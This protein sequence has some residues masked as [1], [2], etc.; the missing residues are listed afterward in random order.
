MRA[1]LLILC[2][3]SYSFAQNVWVDSLNTDSYDTLGYRNYDFPDKI[4]ISKYQNILKNRVQLR[5]SALHDTALNRLKNAREDFTHAYRQW[6][7]LTRLQFG[8]QL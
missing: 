1:L 7:H 8:L 2:C 3:A 4:T 5:S 6:R